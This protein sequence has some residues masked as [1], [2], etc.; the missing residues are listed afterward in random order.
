VNGERIEVGLRDRRS[1][2]TEMS[3]F[4]AVI[5]AT[6]PAHGRVTADNALLGALE[7]D[8]LARPDSLLLGIEVDTDGRAVGRDGAAR[9]DLFVAGPLARGT[10][11]ELMGLPDVTHYAIRIAQNVAA[12]LSV[13]AVDP[14]IPRARIDA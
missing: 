13:D 5:L 2:I 7:A 4:D 6:G 11:G 3:A 1:G 10:F 14:V 8:G 12:R 9:D